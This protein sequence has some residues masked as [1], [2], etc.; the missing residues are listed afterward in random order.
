MMHLDKQSEL[1]HEQQVSAMEELL[2]Y[3]KNME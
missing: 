3:E 1:N 2:N